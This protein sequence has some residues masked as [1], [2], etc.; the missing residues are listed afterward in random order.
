MLRELVLRIIL[1]GEQGDRLAGKV[2]SDLQP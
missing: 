2:K 1:M